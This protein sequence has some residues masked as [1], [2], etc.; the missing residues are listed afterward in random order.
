MTE[1]QDIIDRNAEVLDKLNQIEK[2]LYRKSAPEERL[3][4]I[5]EIVGPKLIDTPISQG[6]VKKLTQDACFAADSVAIANRQAGDMTPA[7]QTRAIIH[8]S[9]EFLIGNDIIRVVDHGDEGRWMTIDPPYNA[10]LL[11]PSS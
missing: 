8:R 7:E 11:E 9:I 10:E 5:G 6:L 2:V 4:V 1:E 3:R